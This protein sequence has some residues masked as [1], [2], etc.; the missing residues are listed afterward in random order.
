MGLLVQQGTTQVRA[1]VAESGSIQTPEIL[2]NG[3]I[4][5]SPIPAQTRPTQLGEIDRITAQGKDAGHYHN[6]MASAF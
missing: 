3:F 6:T 5:Q 1:R 2:H 4:L